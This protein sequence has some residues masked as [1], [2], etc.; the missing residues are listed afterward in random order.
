LEKRGRGCHL[1]SQVAHLSSTW[2]YHGFWTYDFQK[3][4][5]KLCMYIGS[6]PYLAHT[7]FIPYS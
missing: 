7:F 6:I 2:L 5:W 4:P 3:L 1:E